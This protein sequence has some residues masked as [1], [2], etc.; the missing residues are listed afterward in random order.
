MA[1]IYV[2]KCEQLT[3]ENKILFYL[4]E[5]IFVGNMDGLIGIENLHNWWR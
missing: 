4:C 3:R 1:L 5:H 2:R